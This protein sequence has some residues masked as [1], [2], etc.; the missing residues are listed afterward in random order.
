MKQWNNPTIEEMALNATAY[1]PDG[2]ARQDGAYT[3][4]DGVFNIPSYGGSD[5]DN[6]VPGIAGNDPSINPSGTGGFV[7]VN[8]KP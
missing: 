5:G 6:G 2:G 4:R 1:S 3:S 8:P 7:Q